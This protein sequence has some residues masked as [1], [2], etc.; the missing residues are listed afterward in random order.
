MPHMYSLPTRV[1]SLQ[2]GYTPLIVAARFSRSPAIVEA[3]LK[4]KANVEAKDVVRH[5]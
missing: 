4:G 2:R 5:S 3:L 1:R